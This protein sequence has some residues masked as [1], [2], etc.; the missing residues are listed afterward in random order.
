MAGW[1]GYGATWNAL[2]W[3]G[4]WGTGGVANG[5]FVLKMVT[6]HETRLY[7]DMCCR[8]VFDGFRQK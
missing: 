1:Q 4:M 8:V 5:F 2:P 6:V 7:L 3:G